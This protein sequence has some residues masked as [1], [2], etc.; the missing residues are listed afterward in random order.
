MQQKEITLTKGEILRT[1]YNE[2]LLAIT[3][4]KRTI[5]AIENSDNYWR[6]KGSV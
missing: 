4:L 6:R 1:K 2:T 5:P 3:S